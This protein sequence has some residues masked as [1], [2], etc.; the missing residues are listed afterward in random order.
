MGG[1]KNITIVKN[2][3][4]S[5]LNKTTQKTI[6]TTVDTRNY[7]II[8][9]NKCSDNSG[10]IIL[11]MEELTRHLKTII[12]HNNAANRIIIQDTKITIKL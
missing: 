10:I 4:I 12:T 5:E 3:R 11:L 2:T 6:A 8:I 9:K 1:I 7:I